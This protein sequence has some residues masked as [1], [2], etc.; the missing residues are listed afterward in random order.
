M[1]DATPMYPNGF[2]AVDNNRSPSW[3]QKAKHFTRTDRPVRYYIIDFGLSVRFS[4]DEIHQVYPV[5]G[6]DRSAPEH[7][8]ELLKDLAP[9]DPFPTDV[10]YLGNLIREKFV[11]VGPS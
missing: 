10:Y 9:H 2:H 7:R 1:F 4:R 5:C 11:K 6:G 8:P 3:K